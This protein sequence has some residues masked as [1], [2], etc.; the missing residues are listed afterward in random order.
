ME[1]ALHRS[2]ASV[3]ELMLITTDLSRANKDGE[4]FERLLK[5]AGVKTEV[6][7]LFLQSQTWPSP[8]HYACQVA[9][10]E[11]ALPI[12]RRLLATPGVNVNHCNDGGMT[13]I[14]VAITNCNTACLALLVACPQ[15]D[16]NCLVRDTPP[17]DYP[18]LFF[19]C[20]GNYI[21]SV[22]V[23]LSAPG[24]QVN[25]GIK[26]GIVPLVVAIQ[27]GHTEVM[28][29][30]LGHPQVDV[31]IEDDDG[32]LPLFYACQRPECMDLLL[33]HSNILVNKTSGPRPPAPTP[34]DKDRQTLHGM[35][36]LLVA[37]KGGHAEALRRLLKH[38]DILVDIRDQDK[39]ETT[40]L[41][42]SSMGGHVECVK[43]LLGHPGLDANTAGKHGNNALI[44]CSQSGRAECVRVLLA[45][46][47]IDASHANGFGV[48]ALILSSGNGHAN[49]VK[50]LLAHPGV[51][52]NHAASNGETAL[53][54]ASYSGHTECLRL[55]LAVPGI[56][57]SHADEKGN[58]A[59]TLA[60]TE[61]VRVLL[62]EHMDGV[63]HPLALTAGKSA[64]SSS[65]ALTAGG[66]SAGGGS[67]GKALIAS[68]DRISKGI[69]DAAMEGNAVTMASLLEENAGDPA[70]LNWCHTEKADATALI[71]GSAAG[72]AHCLKL[73][74]SQPAV[75]VNRFTTNGD[76]AL[77]LSS[78]QGHADCVTLLLSAPNINVNIQNKF[79]NTALITTAAQ[80]HVECT[81]LLLKIP[82]IDLTLRTKKGQ[83]AMGLAK[84]EEMRQM[85]KAHTRNV[86]AAKAAISIGKRVWAAAKKGDAAMLK[87]L[88]GE[89][90]GSEAVL[91]W[92][93]PDKNGYTPLVAACY[94][95]NTECARLLL[96]QS[97][98]KVNQVDKSGQTALI[99]ASFCGHA[100]TTKLLLGAK[101]ID[102]NHSSDLGMTALMGAAQKGHAECVDLLLDVRG[103]D[104][105]RATLNGKTALDLAADDAIRAL[106]QKHLDDAAAGLD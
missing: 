30:L 94:K 4:T 60:K 36:A 20:A 26:G 92:A 48:T 38:P 87:I 70:V 13:P 42:W 2:L 46:P 5:K 15:V 77:I 73:L 98:V 47:G 95:G 41:E 53:M 91:C 29:A 10:N 39:S 25:R 1:A 67:T 34:A 44:L 59:L 62:R 56:D 100:G 61:E 78:I 81:R 106:I 57:L 76:T 88:I 97:V 86:A 93:D 80:G 24:I 55:L 19:A 7:K 28:Q 37:S 102:V 83:D 103:I 85:L 40:P 66:G 101:G 22:R 49:C 58:T 12:V 31:N 104:V 75:D 32:C 96:T 43:L 63:R 84:N 18:P 50:L 17:L 14:A 89:N 79:G 27:K 65:A 69:W 90:R 3:K 33:A 8:L 23:L 71:A 21:E 52:A 11:A 99:L 105:R 74:L 6:W 68:V 64:K 9:E 82:G 54:G 35:S 45:H 51:Y 72:H 16:I